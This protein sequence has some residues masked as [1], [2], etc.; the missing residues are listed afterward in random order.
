MNRVIIWV[1][2]AIENSEFI[3]IEVYEGINKYT[4][5]GIFSGPLRT[6]NLEKREDYERVEKMLPIKKVTQIGKNKYRIYKEDIKI[7][8]ENWKEQN[9]NSVYYRLPDK[10]LHHI[11]GFVT[12]MNNA[13]TKDCVYNKKSGELEYNGFIRNNNCEIDE[14]IITVPE[15]KLYLYSS[16]KQIEA[17]LN[18]SYQ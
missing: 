5:T 11:N 17:Y 16:K 13:E 9:I 8:C 6:L 3:D 2:N 4:K 18:F 15:A 14:Q 12:R 1:L 7:V 10:K